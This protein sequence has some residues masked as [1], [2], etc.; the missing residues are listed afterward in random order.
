MNKPV[1]PSL[2]LDL[3][4]VILEV[5]GGLEHVDKIKMLKDD[6]HFQGVCNYLYKLPHFEWFEHIT[7]EEAIDYMNMFTQCKCCERHQT[8]RP[9]TR[10]FMEIYITERL[11]IIKPDKNYKCKC[12]CRHLS[13]IMCKERDEVEDEFN[14]W[15]QN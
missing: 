12:K 5:T 10:M 15:V 7:F 1:F 14:N 11:T 2:P 4:R 13:R 9:P 6:I 8:H 3:E